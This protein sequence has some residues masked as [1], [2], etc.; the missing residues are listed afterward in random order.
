MTGR[1]AWEREK[2]LEKRG[3]VPGPQHYAPPAGGVNHPR[4]PSHSIA[5]RGVNSTEAAL[6]AAAEMPAPGD[7]DVV[8]VDA[9]G[10]AGGNRGITIG[11]KRPVDGGNKE[12]LDYPAP[13]EYEPEYDAAEE[14]GGGRSRV[15]C[16]VDIGKSTVGRCKL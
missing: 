7:Y 10:A 1:D 11:V 8:D 12:G 2:E 14:L 9:A 4:A 16:P 13:G 6:A 15:S 5:L 3:D